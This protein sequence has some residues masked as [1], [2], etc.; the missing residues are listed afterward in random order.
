MILKQSTAFIAVTAAMGA[1]FFSAG[2][3]ASDSAA[4]AQ[5]QQSATQS[6]SDMAS[7][8]RQALHSDP[9]LLDKHISVSMKNGKVVMTGF[10]ESAGDLQRAVKMAN[11]T[12]GEKNVVNKLTI[13]EGGGGAG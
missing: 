12:A 10:V 7:R 3:L 2:A 6:G 11:D 13:K 4:P 8:V 5:D 9:S 1:V